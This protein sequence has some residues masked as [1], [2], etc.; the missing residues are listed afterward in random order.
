MLIGLVAL[1]GVL[2]G[3]LTTVAGMGGGLFLQLS[4]SMIWGPTVALA[5]S[6]I[7]LLV[8]NLHRTALYRK[9]VNW[10][11]AKRFALGAAPGAVLGALLVVA[12]P[13]WA[14]NVLMLGMTLLTILRALGKIQITPPASAM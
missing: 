7:A 4:L 8:G 3:V 11:I 5:T 12:V 13:P 14:V 6:S 1:L 9:S 2:A 10:P